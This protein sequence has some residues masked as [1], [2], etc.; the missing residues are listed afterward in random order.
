M[1]DESSEAVSRQVLQH[2]LQEAR[3]RVDV[4][5]KTLQLLA[6]RKLRVIE[7]DCL[8]HAA[9][10]RGHVDVVRLMLREGAAPAARN[11]A[12]KTTYEVAA[13]AKIVEVY[14]QE[15]TQSVAAGDATKTAALLAAG[16]SPN[17][18]EPGGAANA[19][20]S[21]PLHWSALFGHARVALLLLEQGGADV[22]A[23]NGEGATAL[24]VACHG[25]YAGV[26]AACL[27]R[28]DVDTGVVATGGAC[29]G[30]TALE[31]ASTDEVRALLVAHLKR[32]FEAVCKARAM[33]GRKDLFDHMLNEPKG[34]REVALKSQK[35]Y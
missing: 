9:S 10:S 11:G 12:G 4:I 22:N 6:E 18:E 15:L 14:H 28:R 29:A 13:N 26:A 21:K 34:R 2:A 16:L 31:A 20:P 35:S 19:D 25:G 32:E 17:F 30:K 7:E 24:H 23:L 33:E 5:Q 1:G 27:S 8:L 3:P